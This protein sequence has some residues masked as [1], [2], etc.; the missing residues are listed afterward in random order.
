SDREILEVFGAAREAG[1]LTLVHAENDDA[2][3]WL[4]DRAESAGEVTP[5]MHARTR[6]IPVEREATHRAISLAE[7]ADVPVMIVHVSNRDAME[8]IR[9]ARQRGLRVMGETCPQYLVLTAD[10]LDTEGFDG[11]KQVCSPPPRDTE[12]QVA[13]WEGITTGVFD[14]FSSDHCPFRYADPSGKQHPDGLKSFRYI[15]NGIPGIETRLP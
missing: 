3:E 1:V 5:V 12:S 14:V 2:I 9:R 10:D 7:I 4:R 15:P 11:A 13:C 6:P 8:E